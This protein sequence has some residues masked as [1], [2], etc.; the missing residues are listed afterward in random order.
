EKKGLPSRF[1][2]HINSVEKNLLVTTQNGIYQYITEA[3]SFSQAGVI[4]NDTLMPKEW[5][6]KIVDG[7]NG[8]I[9]NNA[10]DQKQIKLRK[11]FKEDTLVQKMLSPVQSIT[12][13]S[14]YPETDGIVWFSG[15][16]GTIRFDQSKQKDFSVK[17]KTLIRSVKIKG[18]SIL[19]GG[20]EY[21]VHNKMSNDRQPIYSGP[22]LDYSFNTLMFEFSCPS[23]SINEQVNFRYKL[24]GFDNNWSEWI[25]EVQKEYTNLPPGNYKFIVQARNIYRSF[26][27]PA[28]YQFSIRK[29]FYQTI[30]ALILYALILAFIV[31]IVIRQRSKKLIKEKKNLEN[32]INERTAEV[33]NQKEEIEKQSVELSDK[34]NEL[35]KINQIVKS[36]NSEINSS[37]LC[38]SILEKTRVISGVEKASM[39][40]R[41]KSIEAFIFKAGYGWDVSVV[42]NVRLTLNEADE[43]YLKYADEVYEDIFDVKKLNLEMQNESLRKMD[44]S[45]AMLIMT[46]KINDLTEGFLI[47]E[48]MHKKRVF[49]VHDFSLLNNLKEHII[50]AFIKTN[51]LEDLQTTLEHLKDTQEQLIRQEKLA[52]IG[53]LTKGIVDRILNPL[54]YINNFS[55]LTDDLAAEI[56]EAFESSKEE[57]DFDTYNDVTELLGMVQSNVQK[58]NEH[59]NSASRIIK[60]MEKLLQKK[61]TVFRQTDINSL[62][63]NNIEIAL[64]EYKSENKSFNAN[65][66]REFENNTEKIMVLPAELGA[67]IVNTIN[68]ACFATDEKAKKGINYQP[69]IFVSSHFFENDVEIRIKDN[70]NGI[71]ESER[72]KIFSPF[73]TTK[74]TS[75]GTGLGLYMNM[76]IVKSHKGTIEVDSKVGEFTIFII[77]LPKDAGV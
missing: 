17:P 39:L 22:N 2:N 57:M 8:N 43:Y 64:Q 19:F 65:I 3:D 41:D 12:I 56:K 67:V 77:R 27:E 47:L 53:Q 34:N 45:K 24:E 69:E 52:S 40:V 15:P 6:S 4:G 51:I 23:F 21:K 13:S 5:L 1:G 60:G 66:V 73:F 33:V 28:N 35:E 10:G 16:D 74:P 11:N 25:D 55:L 38:Q 44:N 31:T 59:G 18:D 46:L 29:P 50:S 37:S 58:I 71:P 76:D 30:F 14:I 63:G 48:N 68:N 49:D 61:S 75:K 9:W 54:N 32:L 20:T 72:R 36:I 42:E 7:Q 70:G 62:L 26:T